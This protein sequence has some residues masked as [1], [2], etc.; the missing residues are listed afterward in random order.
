MGCG[1]T[2]T[3]LRG[4]GVEPAE[5]RA[6]FRERYGQLAALLRTGAFT[7]NGAHYELRPRLSPR[8]GRGWMACVSP[9]S[10]DLAAEL[11][12]NAM[13]GPFKPWPMIRADFARYREIAPSGEASYTLAVYCEAAHKAAAGEVVAVNEDPV[14]NPST[15]NDD[16]YEKGWLVILRPEDWDNVKAT[17]TLAADVAGPY[18]TKMEADGFAGCG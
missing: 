10:F 1:V 9:E 6:L 15:A 13:T 11:E 8:L 17:L 18:E 14:G 2:V 7:R 16:P 4:F 5:T 12:L 3:E